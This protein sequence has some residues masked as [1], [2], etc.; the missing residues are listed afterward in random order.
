MA[1]IPLI[2]NNNEAIEATGIMVGGPK[3]SSFLPVLSEKRI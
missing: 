3:D 2:L 1:G